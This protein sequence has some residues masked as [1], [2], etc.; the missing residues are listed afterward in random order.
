MIQLLRR[1]YKLDI[2]LKIAQLP[3]ATFYYHTKRMAKPDKYA[4]VKEAIIDIYH[5]HK[6]R[7]GYRRIK[8]ALR[9]RGLTINHKTVQRLMKALDLRCLVRMRK[10]RSYKGQVGVIAEDL[11][12]EELPCS[13]AQSEVGY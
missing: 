12:A 10:Y 8:M 3:R 9:R 13:S 1:E 5:E 7:Y 11:I 2:L 6:G 4:E